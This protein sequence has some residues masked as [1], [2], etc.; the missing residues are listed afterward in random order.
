M[1]ILP[2]FIAFL[3]HFGQVTLYENMDLGQQ[4]LK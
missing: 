4:S 2:E 3:T 1:N